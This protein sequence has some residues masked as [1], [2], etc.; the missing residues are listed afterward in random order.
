[1]DLPVPRF[2]IDE[3]YTGP[4]PPRIVTLFRL[5]NNIRD[6]FLHEEESVL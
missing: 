1:M 5:N 3:N 6:D 2:A 4:V